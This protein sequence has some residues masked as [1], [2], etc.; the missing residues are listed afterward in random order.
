MVV[1][2]LADL[3]A[4]RIGEEFRRNTQSGAGA[5]E[6]S[7][8]PI[9]LRNH[10][11]SPIR[12]YS[13]LPSRP[14]KARSTFHRPTQH[15]AEQ[16]SFDEPA[17]AVMTDLKTVA[18]V[19]IDP[20]ASIE[21]ANRTMIRHGVRLLLVAD[22][23]NQ[24]L[25]IITATDVL[26]EKPM[27][28]IQAR[29]GTRDDITVSDIMTPQERLEVLIMDDVLSAKVGHVFACLKQTGRQHAAVV[30]EDADGR[31]TLRGLFSATQIARQLGIRL[32]TV[33]V[34]RTFAEIEAALNH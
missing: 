30:D 15:L 31:Q 4:V 24:I 32:Q 2:A 28:I 18:A 9:Q 17:L 34:A 1:Q 3:N 19:T 10:T 6:R 21:N 5:G 20:G 25:G 26:G 29:G 33:E 16:V 13:P 11:M 7:A 22:V 14:L 8:T 27:Q 12:D 23:H